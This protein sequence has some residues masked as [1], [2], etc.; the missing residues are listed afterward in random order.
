M[1]GCYIVSCV[2]ISTQIYFLCRFP[3][4]TV[5]CISCFD[6]PPVVLLYIPGGIFLATGS[7]DQV[8]RVY[9]LSGAQMEKICELEAH[10]VRM[11]GSGRRW[12][13]QIV[14]IWKHLQHK[15]CNISANLFDVSFD[16][17]YLSVW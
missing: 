6:I 15:L 1:E 11:E 10:T 17:L 12:P 13:F 7:T 5:A 2:C 8:V 9:Y 4:E 14:P 16:H 3:S